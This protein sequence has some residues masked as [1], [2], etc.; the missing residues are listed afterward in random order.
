MSDAATNPKQNLRYYLHDGSEA[1]RIELAGHLSH[2]GARDLQQAWRTAASVMN[3]K[4]LIV[5][6]TG[7]TSIDTSGRELLVQWHADG[8]DLVTTSSAATTRIQSMT[9]LP[10][11]LVED[12]FQ[13]SLWLRCRTAAPLLAAVFVFLFPAIA[14]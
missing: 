10:V 8:A 1:F 11:V 3:G 14:A 4:S 2:H 13:N 12:E 6:L 5:D 9:D 7:V